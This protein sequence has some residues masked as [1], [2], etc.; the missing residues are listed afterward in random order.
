MLE[1]VI[2]RVHRLQCN[3]FSHSQL[4]PANRYET[5]WLVSWLP[6]LMCHFTDH[7]SSVRLCH[8][9]SEVECLYAIQNKTALQ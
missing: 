5:V 6:Q 2:N 4:V 9:Y 1:T 7:L 8:A 3:Y